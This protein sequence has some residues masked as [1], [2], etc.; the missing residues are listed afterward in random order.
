MGRIKTQLI[1]R[2]TFDLLEAH[3]EQFSSNFD[4]NKQKVSEL[5]DIPSKK[6][7][8]IIAGYITRLVKNNKD[9]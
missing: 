2:V 7:R 1:K 5:A 3:R 9:L 8:N 6:I 4:E